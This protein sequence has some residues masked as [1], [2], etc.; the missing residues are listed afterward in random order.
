MRASIACRSRAGRWL[1]ALL[2][3]LL[4]GLAA[5]G[6]ASAHKASDAYLF[7]SPEPD[8]W[9]L[10]WDIAL[11]DLEA[12]LDLD[13]DG[14]RRLQWGEVRSR[15]TEIEAYA[16][17]GL[18]LQ[19][20][21][22]SLAQAQ[23]PAIERRIDGAYLVLRM[24]AACTAASPLLVEYRLLA[25]VDPTHRGLLRIDGEPGDVPVTRA[26]D[27][28]EGIV[29]I[30]WRPDEAAGAEDAS[31]IA[32]FFRNGV[33]HILVGHDHL[34]FL[35]C[36]LLPSVLRR[37]PQ[38]WQAIDRPGEAL[39]RMLG[40]VTMFTMAHSITLA[41]AGLQLVVLSPRI[42][43]PGIALTIAIAA[44][45]NIHPILRGRHKQFA[46][47]FGLIHGFGFAAVLSELGLPTGGLVKA[48]L[49]FNLGVEAG[50]LVVVVIA[51]AVLLAL[52]GWQRY[53]AVV[54]RGGSAVALVLASLWLV[55]RVAD[56]KLMPL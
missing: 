32:S 24:A 5:A 10:R 54:L 4:L 44:F 27:P 51:L 46:F 48:L 20:G 2:A 30:A 47:L 34:L 26:L 16:A 25:D 39:W 56:L 22:C 41:A 15:L 11:R 28:A 55:E 13:A 3:L 18:R 53:V 31:S 50:Q 7:L 9:R 35:V 19:R 45:D 6:A 49:A 36:L 1:R 38:G 33:H 21:E 17:A 40:I 8:G 12:A 43:E 42:V 23:A 52:R 29:R 14:D 37:T